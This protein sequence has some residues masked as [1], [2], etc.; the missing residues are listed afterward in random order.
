LLGWKHAFADPSANGSLPS[1]NRK[2]VVSALATVVPKSRQSASH[3]S[4][5]GL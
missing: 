5:V 2:H 3:P 1:Y 4:S